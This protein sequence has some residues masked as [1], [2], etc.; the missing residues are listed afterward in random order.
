M[1]QQRRKISRNP[2]RISVYNYYLPAALSVAGTGIRLNSKQK[3]VIRG[4]LS[5][6]ERIILTLKEFLLERR[7]NRE[8]SLNPVHSYN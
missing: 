4:V 6:A 8:N 7:W 3:P 5:S 1:H 2:V